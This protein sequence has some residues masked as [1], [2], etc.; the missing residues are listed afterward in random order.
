MIWYVSELC[1]VLYC[2]VSFSFSFSIF[3]LFLKL[4]YFQQ[5]KRDLL[6]IFENIQY[7][8]IYVCVCIY[9]KLEIHQV[10]SLYNIRKGFFLCIFS[11]INSKTITLKI[12]K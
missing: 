12:K 6:Y 7:N 10:K 8:F 1:V 3:F 2:F 5:Q 11:L 9:F 4:I